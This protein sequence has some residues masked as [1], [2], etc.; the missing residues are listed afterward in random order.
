[1]SF[2]YFDIAFLAVFA[3]LLL[4]RKKRMTLMIG[5]LAGALYFIVDYG[6]FYGAFCERAILVNGEAATPNVFC[7]ILL[8]MSISY[9]FTNF[10]WIWL[11]LS[12]DR[13]LLEW[14]MLILCWWFVGPVL[15]AQFCVGD[16]VT[17]FRSTGTT[18][19][20][21]A[22]VF[23]VGY[24]GLFAY[25]FAQKDRDARVKVPWL[26]A[27]GVLAQF[28]WEFFLLLGGIRS[29]GRPAEAKIRT[30]I[31]HSLLETNL[32][33]PYACWIFVLLTSRYTEE[34]KK[35][36]APLSA[37]DRI[38]EWNRQKIRAADGAAL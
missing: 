11:W 37:L 16:A 27:I 5:A 8:W 7:L 38:R 25:N 36:A 14:S 2:V 33:M 34:L 13:D 22:I 30:L 28:G 9:G 4:W 31:V 21:M 17:T 35:R 3:A 19:G 15:A 10:A 29:D 1:M 32:G 12:K 6:I 20:G 24:L 18:H 26:F 23:F